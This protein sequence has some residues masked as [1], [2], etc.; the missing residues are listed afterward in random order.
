ML[1]LRD[2]TMEFGGVTS[3]DR[4]SIE[5]RQGQIFGIIGPNGAGKTTLFNCVTGVFRPTEGEIVLDG[6]SIV[7]RQ[8][9]QH[10]RRPVSPARSRTSAC[11]RT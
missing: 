8:P 5:V 9:H 2:C 6:E 4:V 3:L 10:H 1:G 11:S 7:G